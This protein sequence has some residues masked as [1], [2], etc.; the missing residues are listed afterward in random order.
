VKIA[1]TMFGLTGTDKIF[2][3]PASLFSMC[4]GYSLLVGSSGYGMMFI[5]DLVQ[6]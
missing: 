5:E 3:I 4:Y 6:E 2:D 1:V